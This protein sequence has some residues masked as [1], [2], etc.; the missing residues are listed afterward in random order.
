MVAGPRARRHNMAAQMATAVTAPSPIE[1]L[2]STVN[3][4][5]NP[6]SN[7]T[8]RDGASMRSIN[9]TNVARINTNA[10]NSVSL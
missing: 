8:R 5:A 1:T 3:P 6:A 10:H 7:A 2:V 4:A 9:A